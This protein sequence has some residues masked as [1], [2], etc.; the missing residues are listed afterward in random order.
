VPAT[1]PGPYRSPSVRGDHRAA[2][3]VGQPAASS[4]RTARRAGL[5][6]DKGQF[7]FWGYRV[8]PH[9]FGLHAPGRL[10]RSARCAVGAGR[11]S[12]TFG[13][14]RA[15]R[16]FGWTS[17]TGRGRPDQARASSPTCCSN[18]ETSERHFAVDVPPHDRILRPATRCSPRACARY[19]RPGVARCNKGP[20]RTTRCQTV[21]RSCRYVFEDRGRPSTASSTSTCVTAVDSSGAAGVDGTPGTPVVCARAGRFAVESRRRGCAHAS[22]AN[23]AAT[24]A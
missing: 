16:G 5:D 12:G 14:L 9:A 3:V 11:T 2:P 19:F 7:R 13:R 10:D 8:L 22:H 24:R 6:P 21:I 20:Q 15:A 23:G 18:R 1:P 4:C 17:D